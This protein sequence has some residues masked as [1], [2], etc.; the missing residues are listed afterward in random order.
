[1]PTISRK[2]QKM[3]ASPIRKLVAYADEAKERGIEVLHLNI[4]QPDIKTPKVMLDAFRNFDFD[5]LAY[6]HSQGSIE[7]RTKLVEYYNQERI[8]ANITKDDILATLGGSEALMIAL[9]TCV[10]T[11]GEVIV[12]EPFYANYYGFTITGDIHLKP[13]TTSI[14]NG[15][16]LPPESAF[17]AMI[18]DK[19]Q[20]ILICNPNNPTG[21]LYTIEELEFLKRICIKHDLFLFADEVYREFVYDGLVHTSILSIEELENHAVVIDSVSKRYSA[22]G[23]RL[24]AL[25]SKN[26]EVIQAGLKFAQSRLSPPT[27]SEIAGAAALD[28][29]ESYFEDI[30]KEYISRRDLLV[31]ELNKIEGVVCPKPT[32][33][34]YTFVELP[35]A[36]S[37]HFCQWMLE[38]FSHNGQTVMMA[39]ASGFYVTPGLGKK[40]ARIAY[41]LEKEKL[42][43]AIECIKLGL[44]TYRLNGGNLGM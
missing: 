37:D 27:L 26:K 18:T 21:N 3:P 22:C 14:D 23:A 33:A 31:E 19:T 28:T 5:V 9:H 24:G 44:E 32:G 6:T 41:V 10:D 38:S 30:V 16:A 12:P 34:F 4:G 29:P 15:F 7:Y 13:I 39:P 11:G 25:V 1:M 35:V 40:E 36:D 2:G 43:K 8:N 17:D 42:K 20:A